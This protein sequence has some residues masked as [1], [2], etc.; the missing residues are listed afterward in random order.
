MAYGLLLR[1]RRFP[2]LIGAALLA[3]LMW[4]GG[5]A[6]LSGESRGADALLRFVMHLPGPAAWMLSA[7]GL[8]VACIRL[9]RLGAMPWPVALALGCAALLTIDCAAGTLGAFSHAQSRLAAVVLL[10]P[11]VVLLWRSLSLQRSGGT[12]CLRQPSTDPTP[13]GAWLLFAA[14]PALAALVLAAAG[15]PGWIWSTEFGGYDA[16]SYHLLLPREWMA[17]GGIASLPHNIYSALPSFMESAFMHLM[18]LQGGAAAG[19]LDAQVLH[20]LFTIAAACMVGEIARLLSGREPCEPWTATALLLGVPWVIVTGSLAYNEMAMLL[21]FGALLWGVL[22]VWEDRPSSSWTL[23]LA[24][25]AAAAIG[26]KMTAALFVVAP[27]VP[28]WMW[29]ALRSRRT[30]DSGARQLIV[31]ICLAAVVGGAVLSPWWL[32]TAAATGS[33]FFPALGDGG[34]GEARAGV[35]H[36]AHGAL[37]AADWWR[38]LWSEYLAAGLGTAPASD[39]AGAAAPWRPFWSVLPW[40]GIASACVLLASARF[41]RV[42]AVLLAVLCV[43][44][45]LWLLLT[46]A[47]GRFLLPTAVPL[48]LLVSMALSMVLAMVPPRGQGTAQRAVLCALLFC[49]CAQPL[50]CYQVDGPRIEVDVDGGKIS[51]LVAAEGIGI[52]KFFSGEVG[53]GSLPASLRALPQDSRVV[54]LGANAVFWWPTVPTYASVWNEHPLIA[55][56]EATDTG[57]AATRAA[58][59]ARGWTHVVIDEVMLNVWR[60]SGWLDPRI[61]AERVRTLCLSLKPERIDAGGSLFKVPD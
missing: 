18:A 16:I 7:L 25:L 46:H 40:L 24:L 19:A 8:G 4:Y 48:A 33:P 13:A 10:V 15:T 35:F 47:K 39:A 14:A 11:G 3:A 12:A 31:S 45:A 36:A 44:V 57:V 30:P 41:R 51:R 49:W 61:T 38:A 6:T 2:W 53:E 27:V 9:L 58:L 59:R 20:A 1:P 32:R 28:L 60:R 26:V 22:F 5:T 55:A 54:T 50:W 56:L 21:L 37:P 17:L 34:L 23:A 43:Q 42:A 52:E 29:R